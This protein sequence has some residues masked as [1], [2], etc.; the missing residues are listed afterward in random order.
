MRVELED[1]A[2]V[3]DEIGEVEWFMLFQL[4]ESADFTRSV[5]GRHRILPDVADDEEVLADWKEYVQ[6]EL[7]T[8]FQDEV[9]VVSA[10]LQRA[11]ELSRKGKNGAIYRLR[12]PIEHTTTW[13]SVLNQAR[14]ILN[15]EHEIARTERGLMAGDELPT[16]IDEE[17]WLVMV[18]YRVYGAIQEFLLSYV[19]G[20]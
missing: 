8:R 20:G 19:M 2:W 4:P 17:K 11:E 12:V 18:Q 1:Q 9:R 16:A 5:K 13:Y 15:E 7:E 14:L 10:D 6:P 3:L